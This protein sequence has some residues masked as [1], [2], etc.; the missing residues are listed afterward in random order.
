MDSCT[1]CHAEV[2]PDRA[3][4][5]RETGRAV[6]CMS[7]TKERSKLV[8]MDYGHKTAGYAVA[9]PQNPEAERLAIRAYRRAR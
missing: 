2:A 1:Y 3:E 4:F 9:I 7:C 8:L 6:T 5:L